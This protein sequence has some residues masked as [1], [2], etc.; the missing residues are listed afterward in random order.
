[1]A[2][3]EPSGALEQDAVTIGRALEA[4]AVA[5]ARGKA[6]DQSD[7]ATV[8]AAEMR[9]TGRNLTVPGGVAT[10]AQAAADQNAR[11]MREE[12]KLKLRDVLSVR[13][14]YETLRLIVMLK[15]SR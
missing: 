6:V 13:S 1:M 5:G 8:Q 15:S 12:D 7:A 9:A 11:T 4:A 10:V 3:K 14:L 2:A